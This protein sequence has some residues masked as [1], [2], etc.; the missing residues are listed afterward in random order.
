MNLRPLLSMTFAGL[1]AAPMLAQASACPM[2]RARHVPL[3][4]FYGPSQECGGFTYTVGGV[5]IGA[6]Q[7]GCPLF[8][9]VTPP[10]DIAEPSSQETKV[11]VT[12]TSPISMV[13]F[14]CATAWFLIIPVGSDCT[15]DQSLVIGTVQS[16]ITVP[17]YPLPPSDN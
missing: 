9:I 1:L 11:Q 2:E 16:L 10:H 12:G 6:N 4:V 17:C 7:K 5:T 13:T 14:Y 3:D 15:L 8:I